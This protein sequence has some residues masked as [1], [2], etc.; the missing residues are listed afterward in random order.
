MFD[1][2]VVGG[3]VAGSVAARELGLRG[4]KVALLERC[5]HPRPKP[6]GEGLLPH[7]AAALRASGLDFPGVPVRGLRYVSPRGLTAV[8]D[9]PAGEGMVVRRERFDLSLFEAAAATPNVEACPQ[10]P[11]DPARWKARWLIGADGLKSQ[12]H[13]R[14]GLRAARPRLRRVGLSTH[15]LGLEV[16]RERVEVIFHTGGEVYLAPSDGNEALVACLYRQDALPS[17][18]TNERRVLATLRSLEALRGRIGSIAFTTPVL[19]AGPLGLS[20]NRLASGDVILIGDAAGAP[21]PVTGEGMSL[22]I[23]S[24]RALADALSSGRPE[25]YERER[26][27]LAF[28]AQWL[29][30][31]ILK[32]SRRPSLADRVIAALGEHPALFAKLMGIAVGSSSP[33]DLTL[34][35]LARLAL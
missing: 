8:A 34:A 12:F 14:P 30:A 4:L 19:G 6:C 9:F 16:D 25:E 5:R 28:N 15:V 20:L 18:P 23:L 13:G 35:D 7:G 3:G 22:A 31:W 21:D 29:S 17:E 26:R 1:A 27:R 33:R 10:T 32:A 24:A 11:Y 2:V